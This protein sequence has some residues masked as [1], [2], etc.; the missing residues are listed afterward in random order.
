MSYSIVIF[1]LTG[2]IVY[3]LSHKI[4]C[5][6]KKLKMISLKNLDTCQDNK[7]PICLDTLV[8]ETSSLLNSN[9]DIV[10]LEVCNN[11][12]HPFHKKCIKESIKQLGN[13]CP[14]CRA[15]HK[16]FQTTI[17]ISNYGTLQE[18]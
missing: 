11:S 17:S 8:T 13:Q 7:C 4:D 15:D 9:K 10:Y 14:V 2:I 1:I 16:T 3:Y 18:V 6:S 5:C 12:C